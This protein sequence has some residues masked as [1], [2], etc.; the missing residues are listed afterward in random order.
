M[1]TDSFSATALFDVLHTTVDE[2]S[3]YPTVTHHEI[4]LIVY[5]SPSTNSGLEF[6]IT[7][8]CETFTLGLK[9]LLGRMQGQL[10][11][12]IAW[13]REATKKSRDEIIHSD[14]DGC[15]I[16]IG[17]LLREKRNDRIRR[18]LGDLWVNVRK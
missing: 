16:S 13:A 4:H 1:Y 6:V 8:Q 18:A 10:G 9:A 11:S 17:T 2:F 12:S 5:K 3:K 14:S 7:M 15:A